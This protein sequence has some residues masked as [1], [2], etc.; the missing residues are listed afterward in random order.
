MA[1]H[2]N[3][4]DRK[5]F[6][7]SRTLLSILADLNNGV[8][9]I[10]SILPLIYNSSSP[11]SRL[12]MTVSIAL[13]TI[14]ITVTLMFH[15]SLTRSK[16]FLYLFSFSFVSILWKFYEEFSL[17]VTRKSCTEQSMISMK[18]S[19]TRTNLFFAKKFCIKCIE[20]AER[21]IIIY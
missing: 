7:V 5:S 21:K 9:W 1:F 15:S 17:Y 4:S 13:T 10:V 8:I 16:Y 12:L 18:W 2:W 3:P 6:Q 19:C 20:N 11:F 14:S